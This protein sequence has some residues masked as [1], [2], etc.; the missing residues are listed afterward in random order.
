MGGHIMQP[1]SPYELHKL[2][3]ENGVDYLYF[4]C[5]VKNACSMLQSNTLM[6]FLTLSLKQLPM[7]EVE[8]PALYK[9]TCMWN[10][11]PLYI[12]NLHGYFP[13]QNKSGP[14]CFKISTDFLSEIHER[15]LYISKRN[16]LNWKK[17]LKS[18]DICYSC[19]SEFSEYFSTLNEHRKIHKN[20]ILIR[21]KKS[22]IKLT[23]YLIDISLDYLD[24]RHLLFKKA[25]QAIISAIE[26]AKLNNVKLNITKCTNFCFCQTNYAELS[27][28]E[29]EKL[30]LPD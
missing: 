8:K 14:V 22:E 25:K 5:S 30:F 10:K 28:D 9:N 11:I 15:D 6:S 27:A 3:K 16:P 1:V 18:R 13:R 20:I 4:S 19:V 2:L 7:T 26:T 23:D 17:N 24:C 21:D 12:E 29:I